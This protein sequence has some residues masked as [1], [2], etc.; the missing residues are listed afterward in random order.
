MSNIVPAFARDMH[1]DGEKK[2]A[3]LDVPM[4]DEMRDKIAAL[5]VAAGFKSTASYARYVLEEHAD[6]AVAMLQKLARYRS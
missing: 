4:S 1:D 2:T 6:G 3:R 5:A